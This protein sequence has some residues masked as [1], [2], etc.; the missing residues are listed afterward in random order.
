M[1]TQQ[2]RIGLFIQT[3]QIWDMGYLDSIDPASPDFKD[4][5]VRLYQQINNIALSLNDKETGYY[6]K[7]VFNNGSQWFNPDDN[8]PLKRRP[9]YQVV[10]DM[11]PILAGATSTK[12]HGLSIPAGD[13]VKFT[14]IY[15]AAT[16]SAGVDAYP[17]PYVDAGGNTISVQVNSTNVIVVNNTAINFTTVYIVL[18]FLEY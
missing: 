1:L 7:N 18:E 9:G 3:T 13:P 11:G 15:G 8:S 14:S 12:P 10:V 2:D 17:I 16:N 4:L 6:L 5:L